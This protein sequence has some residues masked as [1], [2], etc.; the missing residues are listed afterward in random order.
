MGKVVFT[1][2]IMDLLHRGHLNLLREMNKEGNFVI[3]VL[4]DDLSC[5]L[6]KDKFPIQ[7]VEHRKR[8]LELSGLVDLVLITE[9]TNPTDR[10]ADI[11]NKYGAENVLFM[12]GDDNL[13]P[14]AKE[15]L[16]RYGIQQKYIKYT[17]GIS[18][19]K[20]RDELCNL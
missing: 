10:F 6:I 20:I 15:F 2:S 9:N 19:S 11:V 4:H 16:D 14:P 8:N 5:F 18:S 7:T 1:A 17:E 12:R 13:K 3:V